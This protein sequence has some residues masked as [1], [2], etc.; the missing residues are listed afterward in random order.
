V[1]WWNLFGL[2][3][4]DDRRLNLG[5]TT[6]LSSK[7]RCGRDV[8]DLQSLMLSPNLQNSN[9][10]FAFRFSSSRFFQVLQDDGKFTEEHRSPITYLSGWV[11]LNM[12]IA[13]SGT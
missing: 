9:P 5:S 3:G 13:L 4:K 10:D 2:S 11:Q 1:P 7:I 8:A 6:S 12:G